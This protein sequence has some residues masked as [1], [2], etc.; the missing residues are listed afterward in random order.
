M[1]TKFTEDCVAVLNVVMPKAEARAKLAGRVLAAIERSEVAHLV[2]ESL[3]GNH[4]A[5]ETLKIYAGP[6]PSPA[7]VA[8]PTVN[9]ETNLGQALLAGPHRSPFFETAPRS[10][11]ITEDAET[12]FAPGLSDQIARMPLVDGDSAF[13]N[14]TRNFAKTVS[15]G[16]RRLA[17]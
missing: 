4:E 11:Q 1:S 7:K 12:R 6:L 16:G 17:D 14:L 13:H 3:R 2:R 5:L 15:F 8:V 10:S 9:E